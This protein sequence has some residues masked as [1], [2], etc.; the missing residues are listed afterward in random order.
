MN[1]NSPTQTM[2]LFFHLYDPKM[3][4]GAALQR[5]GNIDWFIYAGLTHV[6]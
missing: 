3:R 5:W 2:T 1:I 6:K 4:H